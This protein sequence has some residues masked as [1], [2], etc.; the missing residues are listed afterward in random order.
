MATPQTVAAEWRH[1][2]ENNAKHDVG[3]EPNKA[4]G[5]NPKPYRIS[6]MATTVTIA[7][8]NAV[9]LANFGV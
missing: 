6:G 4:D 9:R 3:C 2:E 1:S 7:E 5:S 8:R